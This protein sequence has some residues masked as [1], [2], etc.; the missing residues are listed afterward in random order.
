MVQ[1]RD[2]EAGG[3]QS[4][5]PK[6]LRP[7]SKGKQYENLL[8]IANDTSLIYTTPMSTNST[9]Q[10]ILQVEGLNTSVVVRAFHIKTINSL[11]PLLPLSFSLLFF[12]IYG[13]FF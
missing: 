2:K 1:K 9:K 8:E 12:T 5:R 4:R 6:R 3:F 13:I 10:D 7:M 11:P